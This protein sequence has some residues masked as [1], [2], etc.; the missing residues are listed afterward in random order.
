MEDQ[1]EHDFE[2]TPPSPDSLANF[3]PSS[4]RLRSTSKR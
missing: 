3:Q 2:H 1:H 4:Q